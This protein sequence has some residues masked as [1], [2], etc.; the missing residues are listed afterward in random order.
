[1]AL[2]AEAVEGTVLQTALRKARW[3]LIPLLSICYL[4]AFMDRANISFAAETMNRDLHFTPKI[5]GLGAGLFFLSY[6]LCEIPSSRM[7]LRFGARRWLARIMLTWGLLAAAMVLIRTP[8]SFYSMRLLLGVAEAGY[9]PGAIFYLSEWF[10]AGERARAIGLFYMAYPL[11]NVVMGGLAGVLLRQNGKLGLAGWQWLFLVE[12]IPAIVLSFVVWFCLSEGPA[13]AKWLSA[14]E[15]E[16]LVAELEREPARRAG[17][18]TDVPEAGHGA[19]ISSRVSGTRRALTSGWAWTVGL[20]FFFMLGSS[21]AMIFSLPVILK[22]LTKWDA[23]HVGYLIAGFG[24]VGAVA[25]V[26]NAAHSDKKRELRWH[27]VIPTVGIAVSY[28]MAGVHLA[29]WGA[30]AMLFVASTCYFGLQG[31][32]T[33]LPSRVF[34]GEAGAVAIAMMTMCGIAGGFVGPYWMGW[35]REVTGGYAVGVGGLFGPALLASF[36]MLALLRHMGLDEKSA[37]E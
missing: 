7:L 12:A 31:P 24:I 23:A 30:V 34:S 10:P 26:G 28:L 8:A 17:V 29:G 37:V 5:Y 16:A 15:R 22:G 32:I 33:S 11:S 21:Y 9:F 6:A 27:I 19:P 20:Y 25:M 13:T 1:M 2:A 35:M 14:E 3:R 36:C 18:E 4:V